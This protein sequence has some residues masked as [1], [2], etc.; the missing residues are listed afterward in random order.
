MCNDAVCLTVFENAAHGTQNPEVHDMIMHASHVT[1]RG[2]EHALYIALK[3][4][5]TVNIHLEFCTGDTAD[6]LMQ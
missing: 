5:R 4:Q 6:N 3:D 1:G 2:R